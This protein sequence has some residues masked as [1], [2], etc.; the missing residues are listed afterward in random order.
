MRRRLCHT[1]H[2]AARAA[3]EVGVIA[4]RLYNPITPTD[5][6]EWDIQ[7]LTTA[8]RH[9]VGAIDATFLT[10]SAT[11][12]T[13]IDHYEWPIILV[14]GYYFLHWSHVAGAA[15]D[16]YEMAEIVIAEPTF[17]GPFNVDLH[18]FVCNCKRK[19]EVI[20]FHFLS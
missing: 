6:V 18:P 11:T 17:D 19:Y 14:N 9:T 15:W 7:L 4:T 13:R 12:I 2:T 3:T 20:K 16:V 10:W 8:L 1:G 5:L